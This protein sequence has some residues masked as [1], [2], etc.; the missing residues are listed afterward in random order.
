MF[1]F[2]YYLINCNFYLYIYL[3]HN[4]YAKAVELLHRQS[5][6][7]QKLTSRTH[8]YKANL[9]LLIILFAMGDE[10]EASK[11]FNNMCGR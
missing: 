7:L 10:V 8:Q 5:V 11:Q 6:I 4:R 2:D 9:S 3:L 1:I